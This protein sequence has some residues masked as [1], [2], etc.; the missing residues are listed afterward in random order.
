[1]TLQAEV[2]S[3]ERILYS[4]EADMVV[5]RT[6]AG[7]IAFLS[8]HAPFLGALMAVFALLQLANPTLMRIED[9]AWLEG[10]AAR[11]ARGASEA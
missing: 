7:E 8:N 2:V 3:P 4:G 1:M 9:R 10:F 6:V 5:A 11:S